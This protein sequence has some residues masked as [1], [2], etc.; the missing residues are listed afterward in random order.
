[1]A[2]GQVL[3]V[4]GA[5]GGIGKTTTCINL[6]AALQAGDTSTLVVESDLAM[7]NLVDFL[8]L[9]MTADSDP[10]LHDVLAGD[11]RPRDA[12]Y[13]STTGFDV[14][15]GG[16][17]LQDYVAADPDGL[18]DVVRSVRSSYDVVLLDV[19]AGLSYEVAVPLKSADEAILVS[20]P[21]VAS[22]RDAR[23]TKQLAEKADTDIAGIIFVKSG[24]GKAPPPERIAHFLEVELLGHVPEDEHVP[25]AQD[26]GRPVVT[27][28]PQSPAAT[29]YQEIARSI[30]PTEEALIDDTIVPTDVESRSD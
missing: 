27:A 7:P 1:M 9:E 23:K 4:A 16:V 25:A 19:G 17:T 13:E 6:A 29:A 18:T 3:A 26:Q 12:I 8:T 14:L 20:S 2:G 10:T 15:P 5:K 22:V 24:S 11:V 28:M 21:R 30:G